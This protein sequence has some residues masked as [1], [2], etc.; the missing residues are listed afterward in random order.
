MSYVPLHTR[1]WRRGVLSII[2]LAFAAVCVAMLA[3]CVH[4]P[5]V[6]EPGPKATR[7][8]VNTMKPKPVYDWK[9]Q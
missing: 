1:T 7:P 6:S 4:E 8:A 5:L 3:G 2:A 9:A